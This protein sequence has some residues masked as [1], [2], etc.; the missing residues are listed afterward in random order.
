M[1]HDGQVAVVLACLP[2]CLC[3]SPCNVRGVLLAHASGALVS[4]VH[5]WG[6]GQGEFV[7]S[8]C[9]P[10][11]DGD[12]VASR[13]GLN[14]RQATH[15]W[16]V[17]QGQKRFQVIPPAISFWHSLQGG[18]GKRQGHRAPLGVQQPQSAHQLSTPPEGWVTPA[19]S[20][21]R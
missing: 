3:F 9:L 20:V 18:H 6:G 8:A 15:R 21:E 10:P 2:Y 4:A 14:H 17:N 11:N 13:H 19:L 12:S 16:G 7:W 1:R 5:S